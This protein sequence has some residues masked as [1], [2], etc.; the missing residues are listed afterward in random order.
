MQQWVLIISMFST[1]DVFLEEH[2]S[3]KECNIALKE[4]KQLHKNDTDVKKVKCELAFIVEDD[5]IVT[6]QVPDL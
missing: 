2:Q 3:K 6:K 1:Q 5:I 4:F